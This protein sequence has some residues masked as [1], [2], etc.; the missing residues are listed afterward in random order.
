LRT[1]RSGCAAADTAAN[2]DLSYLTTLLDLANEF[3]VEPGG[4]AWLIIVYLLTRLATFS[5]GVLTFDAVHAF[6]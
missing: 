5:I 4:P 6:S 2:G 3:M 1:T